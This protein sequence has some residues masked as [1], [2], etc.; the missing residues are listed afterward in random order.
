MRAQLGRGG[1]YGPGGWGW[2]GGGWFWGA[3]LVLLGAYFLLANL[4]LLGRVRADIFWPIVLI[5]LGLVMLVSR[6]R[7]WR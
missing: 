3:V 2:F 4:G 7:W 5:L 6:R 1:S